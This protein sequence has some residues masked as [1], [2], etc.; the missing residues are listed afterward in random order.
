MVVKII[1]SKKSGKP[2][3]LNRVNCG[4]LRNICVPSDPYLTKQNYQH[5]PTPEFLNL[6][7]RYGTVHLLYVWKGTERQVVADW[8]DE[9]VLAY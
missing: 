7:I 9:N 1:N 6:R 8:N 3:V 2:K 4:N 5:N